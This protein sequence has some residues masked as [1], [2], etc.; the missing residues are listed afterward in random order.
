MNP[1]LLPR[2]GVVSNTSH[3][4]LRLFSQYTSI[5]EQRVLCVGYADRE[6]AELVEPYAPSELVCLT[7]WTD[8]PDAMVRRHRIVIGDLCQHTEFRD[9]E[10]DAVL[11]F[12]VLE[13]LHNVEAAFL[14]MR[15][16]LKPLGH[17]ALMFGPAWSCAYGH[18][19]FA[20][21]DDPN[22][23]FARWE[24]PAHMHLLCDHEEIRDWYRRRDYTK[25]TGD[26]V[27]HWFYE[28]PIINRMFYDDYVRLMAQHFQLVASEIMYNDL[29][30]AHVTVL[31][32]RFP[33]YL[34]FSSYGGKFLLR[35]NA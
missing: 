19:I 4:F 27:L 3:D 1:D 7:N 29:P 30:H 15:R 10:F 6:L 11:L 9:G 2:A 28:T 32:D 26:S 20:D 23:N 25:D 34:D 31:R 24:L 13:H 17:V 8:H 12:S 33:G 18:H 22:L 35:V 21:A 5:A 14:E 16:I